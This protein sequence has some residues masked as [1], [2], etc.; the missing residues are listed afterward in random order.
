VAQ[1]ARLLGRLIK[2]RADDPRLHER[3]LSRGLRIRRGCPRI[4]RWNAVYSRVRRPGDLPRCDQ[5]S[6]AR[7]HTT[8]YAGKGQRMA[9]E[10]DTLLGIGLLVATVVLAAATVGLWMSTARWLPSP[11]SRCGSRERASA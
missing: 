11:K 9:V 6:S 7:E 2:I 8:V 5:P 3:A 10:L 1:E 4:A